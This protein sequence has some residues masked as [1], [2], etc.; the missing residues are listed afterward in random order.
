MKQVDELDQVSWS[1]LR[2]AYGSA[3]DVPDVLRLVAEGSWS[4][5]YDGLIH[6]DDYYDATVEAVPFLVGF[7]ADPSYPGDRTCCCSSSSRWQPTTLGMKT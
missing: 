4:P 7:I 2:H 3:E 1:E 5:I 6:Q